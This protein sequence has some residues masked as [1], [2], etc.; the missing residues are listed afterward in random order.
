MK[1][2][3]SYKNSGIEW[4]GEIPESWEVKRLGSYFM[5]RNEKVSDKEFKP[6]SVTKNGI[7]PQLET[8][9]KTNDGDNRKLVKKGD[10]VINSR[11]DRKGS[12][13]L[14]ELEGS[15]SLIN[16]VLKP[17]K[18]NSKF[19]HYLFKSN[20]FIEEFYRNGHGIVAD[21]WT[22][23]FWDMKFI[24][25]AMPPKQEQEK[26]ASFLDEKTTKIYELIK[27]KEK[28]IKLLKE[29]KEIVIND[30][31]T[32]GLNK[33][34]KMKNSGIEW[35]GEIPEHWEV[36][37]IKRI[38][39]LLTD[40]TANGSFADLSKNVKYLDEK[41]YARLIRLTDIRKSFKG[42]SVYIDKKSYEYLKKSTLFGGELLMANVGA[43]SGYS[44]LIP[45]KLK[46]N[47]SL[48]PNMF[49]IKFNI[50]KAD[51]KFMYYLL[52]CNKILTRLVLIATSTAQPK[53]NKDNVKSLFIPLS[54]LNEQKQIV[55]Y[56]ENEVSKID[57]AIELQQ[58][59]INK[60]K[61]YK[62]TLIDNVVTGKVKV[63]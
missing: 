11:S 35:L 19:S 48:A 17:I 59:Y 62:T 51:N 52:N 22:T 7:V 36:M 29:R 41:N 23:R 6:L 20:G 9:A 40:Y 44:F 13:G 61:E 34:V 16:I 53:L 2:Y 45:K 27:Q 4:L 14:S 10:F 28:L 8:A 5:N 12:S 49:L 33:N 1:K 58:N 57:K 55:E 30:A 31:V 37:S 18:I 26:I 60:L 42:K 56:I 38:I 50:K 15:V 63:V 47:A 32:K 46:F 24:M 3:N 54:P 21:L 25:L 43:Y 39:T